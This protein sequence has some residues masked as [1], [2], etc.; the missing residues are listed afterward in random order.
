VKLDKLKKHLGIAYDWKQDKLGNTYLEASMP[1]MIE[2]ISEKFEKARGKKAKVYVTP[3][4]SGKTLRKNEGAM[5][6][7]DAYRSIVGKI[8]HCATKIAPEICNAV[9]ELVGH[10]S[11]PGEDHWKALERCVGYLTDQVTKALCLRKPRILQSISDCD[12]DY[13]KEE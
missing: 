1:K 8:M 9:R 2:E 7:I 3:G 10:L 5:I 6:D 11:N 4:T 12:S 13:A